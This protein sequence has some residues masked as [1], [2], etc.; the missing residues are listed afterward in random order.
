H[1]TLGHYLTVINVQL[2]K[3]LAFRAQ[4]PG[5]AEQAVHDAK[6]MASEALQDVRRSVGMLRSTQTVFVFET[7]MQALVE[8]MRGGEFTVELQIEGNDAGYS[9]ASLIALY[10]AAQEG[11]TNVQ[12][13]AKAHVTQ[14]WVNFGEHEATLTVSDDGCGF[15]PV[16]L[17]G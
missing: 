8:H 5:E 13:H 17:S 4:K 1:D 16:S 10:R 11:L 15:E 6:R 14:V 9:P 2:E 3:A 12:R 7:A